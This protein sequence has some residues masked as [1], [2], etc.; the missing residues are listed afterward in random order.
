MAN[1]VIYKASA[2]S[3]KTYTLVK[4]FLVRALKGGHATPHR[5]GWSPYTFAHILC[6]T[7]TRKATAEMK[8]RIIRA[9]YRLATN[10]PK[11]DYHNELCQ[12]LE[13][14]P[15]VLQERAKRCLEAILYNYS[16]LSV[17][18][19]D[20]FIQQVFDSLVWE[21]NLKPEQRETTN[22]SALLTAAAQYLLQN[23]STDT[24]EAKA[25]YEWCANHAQDAL[26]RNGNWR[27]ERKL[28]SRGFQ[29]FSDDFVLL[30]QSERDTLFSLQNFQAMQ[31][32]LLKKQ[33]QLLE[34]ANA[35]FSQMESALN[36][37]GIATED[38]S[39]GN[40]ARN[41]WVAMQKLVEKLRQ[42]EPLEISSTIRKWSGDVECW[43]AKSR[44]ERD[45]ILHTIETQIL[46]DYNR[47]CDL[48]PS[49]NTVVLALR[50]LP[51]L[52]LLNELR[53]SL[54]HVEREKGLLLLADL[55]YILHGVAG[56]DDAS[57]I[58]ERM[59]VRFQ[60]LF[61]DEFQD[62]SRL[63]WEL[64]KPFVGNAIA[65]GGMGLLVGDVKQAIYR[66]RGGDWELLDHEILQENNGWEKEERALDTNFRSAREVV[67]FNNAL[68][69]NLREE[70][71]Q[72]YVGEFQTLYPKDVVKDDKALLAQFQQRIDA[73]YTVQQAPRPDAPIGY[74][75]LALFPIIEKKK[76][77]ASEE[78][79]EKE[80]ETSTEASSEILYT[81]ETIQKLRNEGVT[82]SQIAILVREGRT[83][84]LFAEA[85]TEAGIEVIS[86]DAFLLDK[87]QDVQI[88]LA[89]LRIA[90]GQEQTEAHHESL[91]VMLLA[92]FFEKL[93]HANEQ[94]GAFWTKERNP[95][96]SENLQHALQWL[97]SM[98]TLPLLDLFDNIAYG[99][100]LPSAPSE[101]PYFSNLRDRV[102]AFQKSGENGTYQFL[103]T[104]EEEEASRRTIEAPTN[105]NAV[106]IMTIHK[107]KGLEFEV[108]ICP[109]VDFSLFKSSDSALMWAAN[110]EIDRE[111]LPRLPHGNE[112]IHFASYFAPN[113][114]EEYYRSAVD[115]LNL[116]YVAFTRAKYRLY[117]VTTE[118]K[119]SKT[120]SNN[121]S[122]YLIPALKKT[123]ETLGTS[124]SSTPVQEHGNEPP[125]ILCYGEMRA[126]P[127]APHNTTTQLLRPRQY[128]AND[129]FQGVQI[130]VKQALDDSSLSFDELL[131]RSQ[132]A[133]LGTLLHK[134]MMGVN[135]TDDL[136]LL[137]EHLTRNK[138]CTNEQ[139]TQIVAMLRDAMQQNVLK[140]CYEKEQEAWAE[141]E[142]LDK[143]GKIVRPDRIVFFE[144]HTVVIDFKFG[145]E[146][147]QHKRQISRYKALLT[148]LGY[149]TPQG[150]LWYINV[151]EA[152]YKIVGC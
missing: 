79:T 29:L 3:G 65:E 109:E 70:I 152:T 99:L 102:Y 56:S 78:N 125:K 128:N 121:L 1:L 16:A 33:E 106:N 25:V 74:V 139:A 127:S 17:C 129:R 26:L 131:K 87:S 90:I 103:T 60:A 110:V 143:G 54:D 83:A 35:C 23:L 126:L 96:Y 71:K 67:E 63:H 108:V 45:S 119:E 12:T 58:Y 111:R 57:F 22:A 136:S 141:H 89:A 32:L 124:N 2:G 120:L 10:D 82:L 151:Q 95:N 46:D 62:T 72:N 68:L 81:L 55:A 85:L 144:T 37:A 21:L 122:S 147:P 86:Q 80:E 8:E 117:L 9:L 112:K 28:V 150:I 6:V 118:V 94:H 20:S 77:P 115:T 104:Y 137:A 42:K 24:S 145:N 149:P 105:E 100:H 116:L 38:L 114:L 64:L 92:Q 140:A 148:E 36:E 107:S 84:Q 98:A 7:F 31:E 142:F 101:M 123:F 138:V 61:I 41:G 93:D 134:F 135:T 133:T 76:E 18:T 69:E 11:A 4:E 132:A 5:S 50:K 39:N 91:D 19:I 48:I 53:S 13:I 75:E 44:K 49:F 14:E 47:L 66:W 30:P 88:M 15:S 59:G 40:T 97:R 52:G 51:A 27:T 113:L 130:N 73:I 146:Q 34:A 43:V